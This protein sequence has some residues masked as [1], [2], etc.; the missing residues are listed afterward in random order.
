MVA[1]KNKPGSARV[2]SPTLVARVSWWALLSVF[3]AVPLL[4]DAGGSGLLLGGTATL[5]ALV[6]QL[7]VGVT[8]V[9][10]G[11]TV[12][13]GERPVRFTTPLWVAGS[14]ALWAVFSAVTSPYWR[15]SLV[16][17]STRPEA[18]GSLLGALAV[19]F[20]VVQLAD[21][22]DR[23]RRLIEVVGMTGGV[24][25][26]HGLLQ[27]L[28]VDPLKTITTWSTS[29]S[30]AT[31]GNPDMFGAYVA[32]VS[33]LG[34]G[35]AMSE[36]RTWRSRA[37]FAMVVLASV[38][39][40]TSGSRAAWLA[41][42]LGAVLAAAWVARS[43][44]RLGREA[45][46]ASAA[47]VVLV[48]A[49]GVWLA[50]L[51]ST[52]GFNP[53]ARFSGVLSVT[54]PNTSSRLELWKAGIAATTERA[55]QGWGPGSFGVV[56]EPRKSEAFV[57]AAVPTVYVETPHN[58]VVEF[59]SETGVVGLAMLLALV[60]WS[61]FVGGR[62]LRST[63]DGRDAT[64]VLL[65]GVFAAVVVLTAALLFAPLTTTLLVLY[66]VSLGLLLTPGARAIS[67]ER[68]G[69]AL[70]C[71]SSLMFL[72]AVLALSALPRFSADRAAAAASVADVDPALRVAAADRAMAAN[73]FETEYLWVAAQA[74]AAA[75]QAAVA[76][77]DRATAQT[78]F[79]RAIDL[80]AAAVVREPESAKR[81]VQQTSIYV[82]AA[83][84]LDKKYFADAL[85]SSD[86]AMIA[87]P[88]DP[89]ARFWRARV[90]MESGSPAEALPLVNEVLAIKPGYADAAILKALI[91][92]NAGDKAS[93]LKTLDE[94]A[95]H[96]RDPYI[97]AAR[98]QIQSRE[99]T[100]VAP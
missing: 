95:E 13:S 48:I 27:T 86:A 65:S 59:A 34:L 94:A 33:F 17:I 88:N 29:R 10:W 18:L 32:A 53:V 45:A 75:A 61:L 83:E 14:L 20:L 81:R 67:A 23:M 87:G 85:D 16:G 19:V 57:R 68:R 44:V 39:V 89:V 64:R 28:G 55:I 54:D 1:R 22:P 51:P 66:A 91:Q 90:L 26:V 50:A 11:W 76:A 49:A 2:G 52:K 41:W 60:G 9:L 5:K 4:V 36:S 72:G 21:T 97:V 99:A 38:S 96:T 46:F 93:A 31:I 73:P 35:L 79:T 8:A 42:L 82:L 47:L 63:A 7:L 62:A 3:V 92:A 74:N 84:S 12:L 30:S 78:D 70:A 77:G 6:A 43:R 58:I 80:V 100:P 40:Y 69:A 24:L 98:T 71:A 15:I 56:Y 25:A 37:W